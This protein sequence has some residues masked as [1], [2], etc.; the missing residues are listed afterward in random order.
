MKR[1]MSNAVFLDEALSPFKQKA[2]LKLTPG[3]RMRRSFR[4]RRLIPNP[5]ALHDRKLFPNPET[6]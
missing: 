6:M 5:K 1:L 3:E 2:W 4:M